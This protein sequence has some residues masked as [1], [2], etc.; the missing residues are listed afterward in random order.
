MAGTNQVAKEIGPRGPVKVVSV[1]LGRHN[2]IDYYNGNNR[3][4]IR[5]FIHKRSSI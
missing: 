1:R 5:E 2:P 3:P 4:Q